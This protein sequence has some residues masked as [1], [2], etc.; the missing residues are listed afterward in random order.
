[1]KASQI[2]LAVLIPITAGGVGCSDIDATP[3]APSASRQPSRQVA[4]AALSTQISPAVDSMRIGETRSFS[5]KVELS[6]GVP[7]SAGGFPRWSSTNPAVITIDLN[8]NATAIGT[9]A[10]TIEVIFMGHKA[11]RTIHVT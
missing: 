10:T 1:M 4:L 6:E 2:V 5:V 7:P 8:G 9:G 11:T 3:T